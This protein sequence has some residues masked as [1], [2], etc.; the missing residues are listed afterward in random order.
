MVF[1]F[2]MINRQQQVHYKRSGDQVHWL[3]E[4][5]SPEKTTRFII[6]PNFVINYHTNSE[7]RSAKT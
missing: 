6:Q 7:L 4:K 5:A 3:P 1:L 2:G